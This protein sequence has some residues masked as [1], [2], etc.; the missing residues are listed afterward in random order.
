MIILEIQENAKL[1]IQG[2]NVLEN[3]E[4]LYKKDDV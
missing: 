4:D 3:L 2:K 1:Q